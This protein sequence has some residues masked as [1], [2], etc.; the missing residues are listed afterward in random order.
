M[1]GR[2]PNPAG[3]VSPSQTWDAPRGLDHCLRVPGVIGKIRAETLGTSPETQSTATASTVARVHLRT[4]WLGLN[5]AA[6]H[7]G[8]VACLWP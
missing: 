4:A 1:I 6:P 8:P 3:Q 7:S 2:R 5:S